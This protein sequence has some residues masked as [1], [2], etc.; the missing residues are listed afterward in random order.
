MSAH[1]VVVRA[2]VTGPSCIGHSSVNGITELQAE[3]LLAS[4]E[5]ADSNNISALQMEASV[6]EDDLINLK[7]R[8][9]VETDS[10]EIAKIG[11]ATNRKRT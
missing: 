11:K 9:L 1:G 2:I 4:T 3:E 7:E 10:T 5:A 8:L 6:L